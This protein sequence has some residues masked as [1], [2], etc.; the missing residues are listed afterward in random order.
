MQA[1]LIRTLVLAAAALAPRAADSPAPAGTLIVL[2][3]SDATATLLDRASGEVRATI[4]TGTG[5]HEA[6]VSPDGKTA[7]VCNY[8][9]RTAGNSLTVIDLPSRAKVRDIDLGEYRRPHGIEWLGGREVIVTCEH[10]KA[11]ITVD[12][13]DG[14]VTRAI[15]TDQDTSH[16]VALT[17]D[18]SRAFVAN[19]G[20]GSVTA[21]D[22][23]AGKALKSI[24]TGAGAEGID[25]SPDGKEV[26]VANRAAD[27]LTVIDAASLE[28]AATIPCAT[29]PIRV[30]FTPD[31]KSVLVSNARSGEVAV[32]DRAARKEVRRVGIAAKA[33]EGEERERRLFRDQFGDSPVPIGILIPPDGR[34]AYIACAN[35]DVLTVIDLASWQV[36]G[37][38]EAGRE[39][40]GMAFS[41]LVLPATPSR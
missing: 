3:K 40:D 37:R 5:P 24:P 38:L 22:L 34:T 9:D 14:N 28:V 15:P 21:I 32:F 33:V 18:R 17:P 39:P 23:A 35:A 7:V 27:T 31:G 30:K 6:I 1:M 29:F 16:M 12:V 11:V 13:T 4:P 8:G 26:W 25:V 20:S 36:T 2:N 19:I 10:D 41:P